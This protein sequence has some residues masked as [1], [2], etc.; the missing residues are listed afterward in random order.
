MVWLEFIVSSILIVLAGVRLTVYA[1]KLGD[2]LSFSKAWIGIVLLGLITSLPEAVTCLIS[3]ISIGAN[4][5]AI[6]NLL[7]S[8]NFN[9]LL[10][11][12]MDVIYRQGSITD[13]IHAS[14]FHRF[15]ALYAGMLTGIVLLEIW[16]S[17]IFSFP[18]IGSIS[19]GSILIV[20]L[21]F[22][23]MRH[24]GTFGRE[25]DSDH[26]LAPKDQKKKTSLQKIYS[27]L[28]VCSVIVVTSAIILAGSADKIAEMTGL[29][30]TF[31]GSI[32][33]ALVTSLPEMVV[34]IS[35]M[36]IGSVDLAVGNIFGSN[37]TNMLI[38]VICSFFGGA[39]P[40][41]E[42]VSMAHIATAATSILLCS[43]A[44]AGIHKRKS[45]LGGLGI[46]SLVMV[47]VFLIGSASLYILR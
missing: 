8:N 30:H 12:V 1:D 35:A 3:V 43:I 16:L 26:A 27:N 10:F 39:V 6:G 24:L 9:P 20:V 29:G 45:V 44:I 34:T 15:S 33:L 18:S 11:V 4:D 47:V 5:L 22:G 46:D 38:V 41:L 19:L 21:Y 32:L 14:P 17:S 31:V 23:G 25:E 40:I 37:M 2:H 13:K 36:R 28:I 7:G 42:S